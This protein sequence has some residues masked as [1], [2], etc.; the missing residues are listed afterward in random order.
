MKLYFL[1]RV[2]DVAAIRLI[3]GTDWSK[4]FKERTGSDHAPGFELHIGHRYFAMTGDLYDGCPEALR[5]IEVNDIRWLI[6]DAAL[7]F[8]T[9]PTYINCADAAQPDGEWTGEASRAVD[10]NHADNSRSARA[11]RKL[12]KLYHEGSVDTEAEGKA[13][14]LKDDDPGIVDWMHERAFPTTSASTSAFG[15]RSV[16]SHATSTEFGASW[17]KVSRFGI[18]NQRSSP[19]GQRQSGRNRWTSSARLLTSQF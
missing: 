11:M 7:R 2:A 1:Y 16:E 6:E 15:R 13:R 18:P 19:K 4:N 9:K 14:L 3:T 17:Q 10:R 12:K 8:I 5:V